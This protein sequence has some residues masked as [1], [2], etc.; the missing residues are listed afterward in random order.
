MEAIQKSG[1]SGKI[2]IGLDVAASEFFIK[3]SNKYDFSMKSGKGDRIYTQDQVIDL[4]EKLTKKYPI[5]SIEDPFDQDDFE[6]Y[7]RM[8]KRL[9]K[10]IQIVGDDLLVTNPKRV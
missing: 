10:S 3:E 2:E 8:T 5:A 1:H 4:Y 6:T 9:G 7:K